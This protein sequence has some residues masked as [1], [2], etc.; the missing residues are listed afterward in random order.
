MATS[1]IQI[2]RLPYEQNNSLF[3][4]SANIDATHTDHSLAICRYG[5][6]CVGNFQ[7]HVSSEVSNTHIGY[8]PTSLRPRALSRG[9][10]CIIAAASQQSVQYGGVGFSNENGTYVYVNNLSEYVGKTIMLQVT[11]AL[12]V[13]P[14]GKLN[15]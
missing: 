13:D 15:S 2:P 8:L 1:L 14:S 6:I 10:A 7:V 9:M 12:N 5:P 3:T 11:W 4:P